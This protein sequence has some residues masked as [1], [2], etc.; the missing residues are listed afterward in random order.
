[1][2]Q[3]CR[4]V[5]VWYVYF[6]YHLWFFNL[7]FV[8]WTSSINENIV[9]DEDFEVKIQRAHHVWHKII[10]HILRPLHARTLNNEHGQLEKMLLSPCETLTWLGLSLY[11]GDCSDVNETF[12]KT[13]TKTM[14]SRPRPTPKN[15]ASRLKTKTKTF[16]SRPNPR[17]FHQH[18]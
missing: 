2:R 4:W 3:N 14:L 11:H 9:R 15:F 17:L 16:S 7:S 12:F 1:M 18:Q 8:V 10:G 6:N 5:P 13:K